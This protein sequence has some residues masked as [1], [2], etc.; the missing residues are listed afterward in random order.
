MISRGYGDILLSD[1]APISILYTVFE[2]HRR[3]FSLNNAVNMATLNPA[4][5][6]GINKE[7]GSVQEGKC[8]DI[9]V[10]EVRDGIPSVVQTF[11]SENLVYSSI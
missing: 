2:I 4:K 10:V 7:T 1:Y 11:V 3:G 9:I 8:A 6:S 5:A